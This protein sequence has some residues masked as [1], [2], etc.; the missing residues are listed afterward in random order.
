MPSFFRRSSFFI[1]NGSFVRL[2]NVA[3]GYNITTIKGLKN[4]RV[5]ASGQNLALFTKYSGWDPEVSNGGQSPLNRGDDYDTYPRP[6]TITFG[7]QVGL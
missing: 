3:I 5:Y 4:L 1:E 6:R 2:Q 7:V